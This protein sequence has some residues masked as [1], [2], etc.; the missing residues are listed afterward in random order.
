[1]AQDVL[2]DGFVDLCID[3]SLNFFDGKC[4]VIIEA[5]YF[6]S[7]LGCDTIA[8]TVTLV[9]S[10]RDL[11]CQFG[12]GSTLYAMLA[13]TFCICPDNIQIY[14]IPRADNPAGVKAEY[15][16]EITGPATS[17]GRIA[18][19]LGN[20][21]YSV[22][23]GVDAGD[24]VAM[25]AS[26]I[27]A[28][29]P[30]AFP[31]DVTITATG[32]TFTAKNA[33]TVGNYLNP[34]INPLARQNYLPG[35][36]GFTVMRTVDGAGNPDPLDYAS[37]IGDCNYSCYMSGFDDTDL[38]DALR[39]HIRSSW[40]CD[41]PQSFGHGY[42][43]N[44][45]TVGQILADGDNSAELSRLA[46]SETAVN[47]PYEKV[48][49][50]GALSCCTACDNPELS[51]QGASNGVL[52]CLFMPQ[53]CASEFTYDEQVNLREN[54]FVVTGPVSS[55]FGAYTNPYVFNDVTNN[56]YDEFGRENATY[57]DAN[58]RRLAAATAIEIAT[59]LQ[60]FNGL[61]LYTKNTTIKQG[62]LG[63]NPRMMMASIRAWAKSQIGVLFS[64][65]DDLDNDIRLDT[66]FDVAG[67]CQGDPNRLHL[68][69]RYRPP[70]R[71]GTIS[72]TLQPKLLDNCDR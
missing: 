56:R 28:E 72:T 13:T 19:F 26:A 25:M 37:V 9:T 15:E 4:K 35:G 53:S 36:V 3:P 71:V 1:M 5:P 21:D 41:K 51:I 16:M 30:G 14:A 43:Y 10:D 33:G 46:H 27:A 45:G 66:D 17:D 69:F 23:V 42:V 24:T 32:L 18:L 70:V 34:V 65:F 50:Y 63:T 68:F 49:A 64:E 47:F 62:V 38:Q 57:R 40:A 20:A 2:N 54:A 11:A 22:D 61:G 60:T 29:I 58:S 48:A 31:Y 55:G 67:R 44:S 8:D 7:G 59:E 12:E 39:D 6:D 52:S